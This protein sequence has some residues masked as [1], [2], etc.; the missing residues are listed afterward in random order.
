MNE[1]L[2]YSLRNELVYVYTDS[3]TPGECGNVRTFLFQAYY[4]A[5]N[6]DNIFLD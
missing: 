1:F 2:T 5:L 6:L 4:L 3:L